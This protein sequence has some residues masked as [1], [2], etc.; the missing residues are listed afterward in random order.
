M[1]AQLEIKKLEAE[2]AM[3]MSKA[4]NTQAQAEHHRAKT[5]GTDISTL[6]ASENMRRDREN[7][8]V[9]RAGKQADIDKK[10][11]DTA[12]AAYKKGETI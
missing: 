9:T 8:E 11:N 2:V 6:Y 5:S 1:K 3:T 12:I 4:D 7:E 10:Y